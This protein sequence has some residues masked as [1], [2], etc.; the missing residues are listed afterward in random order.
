MLRLRRTGDD[1]TSGRTRAADGQVPPARA[2]GSCC[3][4]SGVGP[5]WFPRGARWRWLLGLLFAGVVLAGVKFAITG[6]PPLL[7]RENVWSIAVYEG[8]SPFALQPI[9]GAAPALIST[10]VTDVAA[11]F[12]AD[13]FALCAQ[14]QWYLFCEVLNRATDQG[15]IGYATSQ[16]GI[17]WHYRRIVLDEPFHLSYPTVFRWENAIYMV[18]ETSEAGHVRLYEAS[19]FPDQWRWKA[20][21]LSGD[22]L[23]D[24]TLFRHDG[25]WWMFVGKANTHDE[26]WLYFADQLAGPWQSHPRNPVIRH[27]A[28]L[29]RPG[30]PLFTYENHLYRLAQDCRPNYGNAL[31]AFRILQLSTTDYAEEPPEGRLVLSAGPEPWH[32]AGM[33][34]CDLHPLPDGRWR[35]VVDGHRKVWVWRWW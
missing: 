30:G 5:I 1:D 17:V 14:D 15:D 8:P 25:R 22:G 13:P 23:A 9:N 6:Q 24:P 35:A 34:H 26:L 27:N 10:D 33:H 32:R 29:A 12:V 3:R 2:S 7:H 11:L 28:D 31:R 4:S 20:D 21:L 19:S 18:P 16:D